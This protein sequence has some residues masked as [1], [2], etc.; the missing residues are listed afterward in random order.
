MFC[1]DTVSDEK[2]RLNR[3]VRNNLGVRLGDVV[4]VESC[5]DIKDGKRIHV[6]PI[7]D[8]IEGI[9]GNWFEVSIYHEELIIFVADVGVPE[10]LFPECVQASL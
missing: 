1:D 3:V 6:L 8:S 2:V 9:T 10:T 5:P 7:A 4:S